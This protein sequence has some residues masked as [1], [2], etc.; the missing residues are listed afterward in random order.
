MS[1]VGVGVTSSEK[2]DTILKSEIRTG[3]VKG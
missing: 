1:T 3:Q 2:G